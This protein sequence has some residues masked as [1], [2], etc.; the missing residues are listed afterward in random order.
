MV[1]VTTGAC[2]ALVLA[3][4]TGA[5]AAPA[6]TRARDPREVEAQKDCLSGR[7]QQGIDALVELYVETKDANYIYNQARCYEQNNRPDEAIS[8][9]E[10]FVRRATDLTPEEKA[11]VQ[12]HLRECEQMKRRLA[13]AP[14]APPPAVPATPT[15]T[16]RAPPPPPVPRSRLAT[17]L[18]GVAAG[19]VAVGVGAAIGARVMQG[20]VLDRYDENQAKWGGRFNV[21]E[22]SA[23]VVGGLCTIGGAT[24]YFTSGASPGDAGV[25]LRGRW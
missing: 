10:E 9:F 4:L 6:D 15:V 25:A 20:K 2:S 5:P 11:D 16:S 1:L 17:G 7:L 12:R 23:I 8:R 24:V 14:S 21:L 19:A 13:A 3:T 22:V 18:F